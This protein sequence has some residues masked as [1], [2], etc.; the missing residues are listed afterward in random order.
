M[1]RLLQN[2]NEKTYK[3]PGREVDNRQRA[4]ATSDYNVK[5]I[6]KGKK[7]KI[8]FRSLRIYAIYTETNA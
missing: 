4:N 2:S 5:L 1:V 6:H 3:M 8:G 7:T